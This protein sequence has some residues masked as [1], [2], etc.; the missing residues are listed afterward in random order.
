MGFDKNQNAGPYSNNGFRKNPNSSH[1]D[2][3]EGEE[4]EFVG[5]S[6][7]TKNKRG[8]PNGTIG[9]ILDKSTMKNRNSLSRWLYNLH[10]H[11]NKQL[12]KNINGHNTQNNIIM[13]GCLK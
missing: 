11:I 10:N 5:Q 9:T 2:F 6:E 12:G 7:K 1:L 8:I 13:Y 3:I 4:V